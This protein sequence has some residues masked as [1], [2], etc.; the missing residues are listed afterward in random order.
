[1]PLDRTNLHR[2]DLARTDRGAPARFLAAA[3]AGHYQLLVVDIC[4]GLDD[5]GAQPA[6]GGGGG[7]GL[8]EAPLPSFL[9]PGWFASALLPAMD[10][11]SGVVALNVVGSRATLVGVAALFARHFHCH[12]VLGTSDDNCV[13]FGALGEHSAVPTPAQLC[14]AMSG[15]ALD[16]DASPG[17]DG[18]DGAN[19]ADDAAEEDAYRR[20]GVLATDTLGVV[21]RTAEFLDGGALLMGWLTGAE[22]LELLATADHVTVDDAGSPA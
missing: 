3:P 20:L 2:T 10:Q 18:T 9:E 4:G 21:G 19:H 5:G 13:F 17:R 15:E 11:R 1:M 8:L 12:A 14:R 22:F 16:D 7:Y 6:A